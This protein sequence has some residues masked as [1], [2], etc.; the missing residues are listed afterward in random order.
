MTL[1]YPNSGFSRQHLA[2]S[3]IEPEPLFSPTQQEPSEAH[4]PGDADKSSGGETQRKSDGEEETIKMSGEAGEEEELQAEDHSTLLSSSTN[5]QIPAET[6][7][8]LLMICLLRTLKYLV[9]DKDLPMLTSAFWS[10]VTRLSSSSSAPFSHR[11]S[12]FPFLTLLCHRSILPTDSSFLPEHCQS[13]ELKIDIKHSSYKKTLA[14][15]KHLQAIGLLSLI[16]DR[17]ASVNRQH[18]LFREFKDQ[19]RVENSDEF[20]MHV[21]VLSGGGDHS[22]TSSANDPNS[23]LKIIDLFKFPRP[24]REVL[25][26]VVRNGQGEELEENLPWL[27]GEGSYGECMTHSQVQW[28]IATYVSL[29]NLQD[30]NERSSLIVPTTDPLY[31]HLCRLKAIQKEKDNAGPKKESK[32]S[33]N[34]SSGPSDDF[35]PEASDATVA[36]VTEENEDQLYQMVGGVLVMPL[37]RPSTASTPPPATVSSQ[38]SKPIHTPFKWKPVSLPPAPPPQSKLSYSSA[39]AAAHPQQQH[40][41]RK[42]KKEK[43][44]TE[45]DAPEDLQLTKEDLMF[46]LKNALVPYHALLLPTGTLFSSLPLSCDWLQA[47]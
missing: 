33:S 4:S 5:Q 23:R 41:Q 28:L 21:T 43:S 26:A 44:S 38:D 14:F 12:Q 30:P 39:A 9:K 36:A 13:A 31:S 10:I 27:M 37:N 25:M 20:R 1:V 11:A 46:R 2:L 19:L 40:Q 18:E 47:R 45:C 7:D 15:L 29:Q 35:P 22:N 3:A 34:S 17:V 42:P 16:T 6:M 32:S 8:S 24:L